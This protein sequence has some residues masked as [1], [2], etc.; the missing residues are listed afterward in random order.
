MSKVTSAI[1][2]IMTI[3]NTSD[4]NAIIDAVKLKQKSLRKAKSVVIKSAL[5]EGSK[6][7]IPSESMNAVVVKVNRT[8]AI[9]ETAAGQRWNVP[10]TMLA[11]AQSP[12]SES[13]A[14]PESSVTIGVGTNGV[15]LSFFTLSESIL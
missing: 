4:L 12:F 7:F 5:G 13:V 2:S 1:A 9:V 3:D 8:K 15:T 14:C 10:L 11:K 6:V